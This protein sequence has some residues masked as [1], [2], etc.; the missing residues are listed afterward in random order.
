MRNLRLT[1]QH[2]PI[3]RTPGR[4]RTERK[5]LLDQPTRHFALRRDYRDAQAAKASILI[6]YNISSSTPGGV[7]E[8]STSILGVWN[9]AKSQSMDSVLPERAKG[10]IDESKYLNF[11]P[12]SSDHRGQPGHWRGHRGKAC[13]DGGE[14]GNS[15]TKPQRPGGGRRTDPCEAGEL[16]GHG[17]R[18]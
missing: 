3:R 9:S 8:A 14:D 15:R 6:A 18:P 2:R 12:N 13:R 16:P 7:W 10:R 17:L 11:R 5:A 4:C 1:H